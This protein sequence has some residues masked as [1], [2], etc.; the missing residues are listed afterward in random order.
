MSHLFRAADQTLPY[1]TNLAGFVLM[2]AQHLHF[3]YLHQRPHDVH[4]QTYMLCQMQRA[5]AATTTWHY[6]VVDAPFVSTDAP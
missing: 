3:N 6:Q 2:L 4:F 1:F 5:R